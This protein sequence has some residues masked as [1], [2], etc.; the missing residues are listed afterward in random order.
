MDQKKMDIDYSRSGAASLSEE[1]DINRYLIH[2]NGSI[3][4]IHN[5]RDI[6]LAN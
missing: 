2:S 5:N 6:N 3:A 1:Y 4:S